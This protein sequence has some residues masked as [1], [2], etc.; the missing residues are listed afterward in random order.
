MKRSY[1]FRVFK[2]IDP[3]SFQI[4][5]RLPRNLMEY[6]AETTPRLNSTIENTSN[7]EQGFGVK[8]G[9]QTTPYFAKE[10]TFTSMPDF[11][12]IEPLN[13]GSSLEQQPHYALSPGV[14]SPTSKVLSCRYPLGRVP[15]G[16]FAPSRNLD[17]VHTVSPGAPSNGDIWNGASRRDF[18]MPATRAPLSKADS[19]IVVWCKEALQS[20][21]Q[22]LQNQTTVP[23][24][25]KTPCSETFE[26]VASKMKIPRHVFHPNEAL[27]LQRLETR[28]GTTP[29]WSVNYGE[30]HNAVD[31]R[32]GNTFSPQL[33]AG[34][35]FIP[36]TLNM[37]AQF[38]PFIEAKP[39]PMMAWECAPHQ[40]PSSGNPRELTN[41][42]GM[43]HPFLAT[44]IR[45]KNTPVGYTFDH[46]SSLQVPRGIG[47]QP[48][49]PFV[50]TATFP[51]YPDVQYMFR[52]A[53]LL[54]M[55]NQVSQETK[56]VLEEAPSKIS[57]PPSV[58]EETTHQVE[59]EAEKIKDAANKSSPQK[60]V[61]KSHQ[62]KFCQKM[63]SRHSALK[64]HMR[65]HTGERPFSCK[66][67]KRTFAQA[68]GLES[69]MRSHTGE[70]PF[71]CDVCE[72]RFSHSTAVRN[73]KRI[74]TGEKPYKC[75][76]EGCGKGFADQSTLKKHRRIHTGE[77]PFQCPHCL[78]K[79]T[80]LGNMNKHIRCKHSQGTKK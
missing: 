22:M 13:Y 55:P 18:L 33:S 67:C 6:Y 73:H 44:A 69:H 14:E 2:N 70:R 3:R 12:P 28:P 23:L 34:A 9:K 71:K 54:M 17:A 4:V 26:N 77:K 61:T 60:I 50:P 5:N 74:H 76:H 31:H 10:N 20:T 47:Y 38:P 64:I 32:M 36:S 43:F 62:C 65:I 58:Q 52:A 27:R 21:N 57:H 56:Q 30:A 48:P 15:C 16:S 25:Q 63:Y 11:A 49:V 24:P 29:S 66:F 75:E 68:G 78:R 1:F 59:K 53:N 40:T 7:D 37:A 80:Q 46:M 35:P 8:D 41:E 45:P 72:R 39:S 51:S 19:C 79:F 42:P